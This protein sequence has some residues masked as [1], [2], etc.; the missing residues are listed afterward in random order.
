MKFGNYVVYELIGSGGMATVH[1]A[2]RLEGDIETPIALKRLR[3]E[4]AALPDF[5]QAFQ[6]GRAHV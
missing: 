2:Q 3:P 6:I 1:R 5:V 4:L